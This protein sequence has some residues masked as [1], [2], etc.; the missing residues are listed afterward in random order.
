MSFRKTIYAALI[1]LL[2]TFGFSFFAT[3]FEIG[4][5]GHL[6]VKG[7][8]CLSKPYAVYLAKKVNGDYSSIKRGAVYMFKVKGVKLYPDD[9]LFVK[10]IV[11]LPGDHIE[12]TKG[13]K[14]LVNGK[15][16]AKGLSYIHKANLPIE[17]FVFSGTLPEGKYFVLG[18]TNSSF[19]SR[20]WGAIDED[21]IVGKA[22]GL[23][24]F[25][26]NDNS[27]SNTGNTTKGRR[28]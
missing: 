1:A 4:V 18:D 17:N 21:Q 27:N 3:N 24:P 20:Y 19:D 23:I 10:F 26:W 9:T 25:F 7:T 5:W 13:E 11:G 6:G 12:I 28:L 14:I 2:L 8:H 16:V 22:Y 15:E